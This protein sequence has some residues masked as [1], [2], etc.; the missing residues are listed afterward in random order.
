MDKSPPWLGCSDD[1]AVAADETRTA[2]MRFLGGSARGRG[3]EGARARTGAGARRR[4]HGARS[5]PARLRPWCFLRSPPP[6]PPLRPPETARARPPWTASRPCARM[7]RSPCSAFRG[8]AATSRW[9]STATPSARARRTTSARGRMAGRRPVAA[10]AHGGARAPAHRAVPPPRPPPA[11]APP[12]LRCHHF[13]E[14]HP[15]WAPGPRREAARA[16]HARRAHAA[17]CARARAQRERPGARVTLQSDPHP[18]PPPP[19]PRLPSRGAA[20]RPGAPAPRARLGLG[21]KHQTQSRHTQSRPRLSRFS[22]YVR[23]T[24]HSQ[25]GTLSFREEL[26]RKRTGHSN[27]F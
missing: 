7:R 9:P 17:R 18:P 16:P 6:P 21:L 12:A 15:C 23:G 24:P 5:A 1:V 25:A 13:C 2:R 14:I 4:P 26:D 27:G 19:P 11:P 20:G 10:T 8:S 3:S 22:S